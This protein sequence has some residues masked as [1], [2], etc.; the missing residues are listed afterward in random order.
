MRNM[1]RTAS[2]TLAILAIALSACAGGGSY[3]SLARRPAERAYG[4]A[5]PV[6]APG[7]AQEPAPVAM[8]PSGDVIS[9]L[10][11][12]RTQAAAANT[13]FQTRESVARRAVAAAHGAAVASES[14]SVAQV[15][16]AQLESARSDA[17]IALAD[18]DSLLI[19]A[20]RADASAPSPDLPAVEETRVQVSN[21]IAA[22]DEVLAALYSQL[23]G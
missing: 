16:L 9:Q 12:L 8:A 17:M 14:W 19:A 21:W 18:L 4:T 10:E 2:A 7:P 13:R 6:P 1:P 5:Q 15:A 11:S 23:R 20:R 3:P 22:Q